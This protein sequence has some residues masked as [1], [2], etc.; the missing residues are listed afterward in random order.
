[1]AAD[2]GSLADRRTTHYRIDPPENQ[3]FLTEE[4]LAELH[5]YEDDET[6][7]TDGRAGD[8]NG[9]IYIIS[10]YLGAA[11]HTEL[12]MAYYK[13]GRSCNPDKRLR[14]LQTGNPRSLIMIAYHVAG[15]LGTHERNIHKKLQQYRQGVTGGTEWFYTDLATIKS[16]VDAELHV[17]L[18]GSTNP[19]QYHQY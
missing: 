15:G 16:V 8:G 4:Q 7:A 13:V 5:V 14:D 3:L 19:Y 11:Q 18:L 12:T 17:Q 1:M 10:E 9:Y 2:R 6:E